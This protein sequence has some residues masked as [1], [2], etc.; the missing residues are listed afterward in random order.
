VSTQRYICLRCGRSFSD[1]T[2]AASY[3]LKRPQ[4]LRTIAARLLSCSGYRQIGREFGISPQTVARHA[5][6]LGR[7]ALLFHLLRWD[8]RSIEEP[9]GLDSFVSF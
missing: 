3:W 6:R 9:V 5:S 2:F 1:R 4:L 7:Q 8:H